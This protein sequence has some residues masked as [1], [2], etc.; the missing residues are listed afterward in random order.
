MRPAATI[1]G[2]V[3]GPATSVPAPAGPSVWA[4]TSSGPASLTGWG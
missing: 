3:T 4:A 1:G 2:A